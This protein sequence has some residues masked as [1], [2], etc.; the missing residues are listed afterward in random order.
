MKISRFFTAIG[1]ITA[2]WFSACT[3]DEPM[4]PNALPEGKYPLEIASVTMS[5]ESSSEPWGADAPQT[6]VAESSNGMSSTW[7]WDGTERIGVQIGDGKPGTYVLNE[8][9]TITAE[10]ACYWASTATGQAVKAW[11]PAT[12]K[13]ISLADQSSGLAYVLQT[14]ETA[15]FDKPVTLGFTHQLAKVRVVLDGTQAALAQSVEVYGYTICT[16]NEG[17]PT[18][19]GTQDWIKMK[20]TIY[21]DGTE[22]WEANVVPG[23]ITLNNFIRLNGMTVVS[24][25]RGIPETLEGGKMYTVDLTVGEPIIDITS[26]NCNNINGNGNYR[27]KGSFGQTITVTGG[28]PHIYLENANISA[29]TPIRITGNSTAT[30]HVTG[31]NNAVTSTSGTG[32]LVEKG[33]TLIITSENTDNVITVRGKYNSP[34]DY[35]GIGG[36]ESG[37]CGTIRIE[38]VTVYAYGD[39][40][41]ACAS[42]IGPSQ[43]YSCEGIIINEA[44]VYAYG[45]GSDNLAAPGIGSNMHNFSAEIGAIPKIEIT[46]STIHAVRGG[47]VADY[48]GRAGWMSDS[49]SSEVNPGT[50]GSIKS[51]TVY[52]HTRDIYRLD[53]TMVY[54]AFGNAMEQ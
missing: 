18:A 33:S 31:G 26:E 1:L 11:F 5:V 30:I 27:V 35:P 22:C 13:P 41:N 15:N 32:I 25:L 24:N 20:H 9:N 3:N 2:V 42:G 53:K 46:H 43:N 45:T 36:N 6:R 50:G 28:S 44:V 38:N 21:T 23:T 10:N 39:G 29:S 48:I 4:D 14:T 47:V 17:T 40:R 54:D 7:E 19:S 52:C 8:G 51:S 49:A 34:N 16:N 37:D 12:D